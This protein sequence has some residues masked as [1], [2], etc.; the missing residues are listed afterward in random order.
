MHDKRGLLRL[1]RLHLTH[2]FFTQFVDTLAGVLHGAFCLGCLRFAL[3]Y[4][5]VPLSLFSQTT[6]F[7]VLLILHGNFCLLE[8]VLGGLHF[9]GGVLGTTSADG[10]VDC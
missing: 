2:A 8:L 7:V 1:C 9:Y 5:S 4:A 6:C 3:C 10:A